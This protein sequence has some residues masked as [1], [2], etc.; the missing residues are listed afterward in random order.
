M[1]R[2]CCVCVIKF[3]KTDELEKLNQAFKCLSFNDFLT[4]HLGQSS[5]RSLGQA[6]W[7]GVAVVPICCVECIVIPD[8]LPD[9]GLGFRA[10]SEPESGGECDPDV[11][12]INIST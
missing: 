3:L 6:G 12:N 7:T 1:H 11:S 10:S 2:V 4:S 8:D 5:V 9:A